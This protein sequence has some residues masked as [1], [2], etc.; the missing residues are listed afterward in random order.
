MSI[1]KT[2]EKINK[3]IIENVSHFTPNDIMQLSQ[4]SLNLAHTAATLAA[5]NDNPCAIKGIR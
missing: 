2:I 1:E 5:I 4:A 3:V